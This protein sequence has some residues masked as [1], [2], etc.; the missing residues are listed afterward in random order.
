MPTIHIER[1]LPYSATAL[2]DLVADV[3]HYPEFVPWC[4]HI[5]IVSSTSDKIESLVTVGYKAIR[6]D[7]HCYIHLHPAKTEIRVE[8]IAGPF[9]HFTQCWKFI[10]TNPNSTKVMFDIDFSLASLGLN[11]LA[12]VLCPKMSETFMEAFIKRAQTLH[13]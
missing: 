3:K 6:T 5:Q 13:G 12:K 9:K 2:F 11:T 10:A 1:V 8:Q 4:E 7:F